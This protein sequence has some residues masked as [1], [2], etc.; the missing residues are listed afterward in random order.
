MFYLI[1]IIHLE[2]LFFPFLIFYLF[3]LAISESHDRVLRSG[4]VSNE[5]TVCPLL[6][7]SYWVEYCGLRFRASINGKKGVITI[8]V[9]CFA[10]DGERIE[11]SL[12]NEEG[13]K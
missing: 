1:F 13:R 4:V 10:P 3:S 9:F 8:C 6:D 12:S 5:D 2:H 7:L 11:E